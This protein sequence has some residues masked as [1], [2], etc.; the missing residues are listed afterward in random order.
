MVLCPERGKCSKYVGE[1]V[2]VAEKMIGR[3]L[4]RNEVVHHINGI[5]LDNQETNLIVLTRAQ[6]RKLHAQLEALMFQ[7]VLNGR[8]TF[9][10]VTGYEVAPC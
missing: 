2:L 7:F 6:H 5:K 9:S 3:K 1:H 10:P 4:L 8:I